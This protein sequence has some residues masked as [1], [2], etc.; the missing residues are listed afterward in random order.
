MLWKAIPQA[1]EPVMISQ[2]RT[3]WRKTFPN[4]LAGSR[5]NPEAL[6]TAWFTAAS[7]VA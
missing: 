2:L 6:F 3:L 1:N 7:V 4:C 5:K